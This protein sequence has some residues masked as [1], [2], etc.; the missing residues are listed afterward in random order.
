[1]KKTLYRASAKIL[2]SSTIA[3]DEDYDEEDEEE[4]QVFGTDGQMKD[5]GGGKFVVVETQKRF[6]VSG[7]VNGKRKTEEVATFGERAGKSVCTSSDKSDESQK[8][9]EGMFVTRPFVYNF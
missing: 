7:V 1:M 8:S 9:S 6:E 2:E 3:E 5:M 4:V